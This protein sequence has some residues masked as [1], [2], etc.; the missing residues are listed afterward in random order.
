MATL[1]KISRKQLVYPTTPSAKTGR[2]VQ[3]LADVVIES[4]SPLRREFVIIELKCEGFY[5]KRDFVQRVQDDITKLNGDMVDAFKPAKAWALAIST[6]QEV[7]DEM[8]KR[9]PAADY[10]VLYPSLQGGGEVEPS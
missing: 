1:T 10:F 3:T 5:N 4:G 9:W 2:A 8:I 7:Y 6:S